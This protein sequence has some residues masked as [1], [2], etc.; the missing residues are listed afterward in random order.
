MGEKS[1]MSGQDVGSTMLLAVYG[2]AKASRMFPDILYDEEAIRIVGSMD[3]DF[4]HID[5]SYGTEYGCLCC[6]M[7]AK[8]MDERCA[9]YLREH[10]RGTVVNLGCG[11]DTTFSR[12]DNGAA[13][14]YNVDL[15]DSMAFRRRFLP[16][17]ERCTDIAKSM[18]D[19]S[20]PGDIETADG[21]VFI[22]AAGLFY[23]FREEEIRGLVG[24][25]AAHFDSGELFFD[26]QSKAT[27]RITNRMVRRTGNTGAG[28]Y[29][30]V[31]RPQDLKSWSPHITSV[32]DV[33]FF[34][35]MPKERRF[36]TGT[37][38]MMWGL[39][40]LRMGRLV[41]IRWK[42]EQGQS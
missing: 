17:P 10:P 14:W 15:P 16:A 13:R 9:A 1:G 34:R 38:V 19:D 18:L 11:L 12:L 27:V 23:Y 26:A 21:S 20:W 24:R 32:E 37:R 36:Q 42:K 39:D 4:T 7:R 2:R 8:R 3:Y 41:S 30:H 25:I 33:R 22:L 31:N 40:H 29:F 5:R 35:N 28:M 6:L